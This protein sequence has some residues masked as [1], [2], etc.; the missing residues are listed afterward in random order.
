MTK[1]NGD[2]FV[3]CII[4]KVSKANKAETVVRLPSVTTARNNEQSSQEIGSAQQANQTR[5]LC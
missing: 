2:N 1:S 5:Q 3:S 4:H